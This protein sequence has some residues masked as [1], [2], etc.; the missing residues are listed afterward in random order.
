MNAPLRTLASPYAKRLA[1]ERG[2]SLAL[3]AGSG[4]NGRIVAGDVPLT[5]VAVPAPVAAEAPA[6]AVVPAPAA[7]PAVAVAPARSISAFAA[8]IE[9]APLAEFIAASGSEL[10]IDAFLIRAAARTAGAHGAAIRWMKAE[11]GAVTIPRAVALAPT[12]IARLIGTEGEAAPASDAAMV[13]SRLAVKGVRPVAGG[14]PAGVTLRILVVAGDD[15]ATAEALI[16]HD[17]DAI[18][19]DEAA[20]IITRFRD[21]IETPLRLLV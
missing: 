3:V 7:A 8:T 10:T 20:G 4:P 1:R 14:L 12:E 9:L 5:P 13:V 11:G 16:V 19:E 18:A 2:V 15:A 17:A 21:L 6:P